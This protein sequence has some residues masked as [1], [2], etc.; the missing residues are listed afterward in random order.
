[1]AQPHQDTL[2]FGDFGNFGRAHDGAHD[3]NTPSAPAVDAR[4]AADAARALIASLE[5]N[6]TVAAHAHF[7]TQDH[8]VTPEG[9]PTLESHSE[10]ISHFGASQAVAVASPLETFMPAPVPAVT[11]APPKS[12]VAPDLLPMPLFDAAEFDVSKPTALPKRRRSE[13]SGGRS[14]RIPSRVKPVIIAVSAFALILLLFKAPVILSQISYNSTPK[15]NESSIITPATDAIPTSPTITIPKINVSAPIVF[16]PSFDEAKIQK[17]LEGGVVHYGSTPLPGERG[18]SVIVGHSSNDWWEPGNYKFV[19]VLLDKLI[20]GDRYSVNYNG[21]KYI[22]EVTV[23]KVVEPT[24]VSVLAVTPEPTMTLIT[25]TPPGTSW[26]RLVVQARQVSPEVSSDGNITIAQADQSQTSSLPGSAPSLT[27]QVVNFF[28]H[29]FGQDDSSSTT[30]LTPAA[31]NGSTTP[32]G[33]GS[34]TTLPVVK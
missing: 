34:A 30:T 4:D 1:M 22:Y 20:P 21:K 10:R 7:G 13:R 5:D 11:A 16:E 29:L 25:C 18:N 17:S 23:V 8:L 26:K 24:D 14:S 3:S 28:R 9:H 2:N 15:S 27:D 6:H 32:T 12:H 31:S 19:F 33:A